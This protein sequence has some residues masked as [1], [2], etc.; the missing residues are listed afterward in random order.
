M[1]TGAPSYL[2]PSQLSKAPLVFPTAAA[3]TPA[4]PAG[5]PRGSTCITCTCRQARPIPHHGLLLAGP[6]GGHEG[7]S[8]HCPHA[9]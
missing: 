2:S 8:K 1:S 5:W 4:V 3:L 7:P 6:P 9:L